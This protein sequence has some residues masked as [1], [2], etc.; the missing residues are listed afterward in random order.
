MSVF[1]LLRCK[2]CLTTPFAVVRCNP[3]L[4]ATACTHL[5]T[6]R[7]HPPVHPRSDHGREEDV[8]APGAGPE[9]SFCPDFVA[10]RL[11]ELREKLSGGSDGGTAES[12]PRK[13]EGQGLP[14]PLR[15]FGRVTSMLL[16]RGP[17]SSGR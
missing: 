8:G 7:P 9:S 15:V 4:H 2:P 1:A 12:S 5:R 3:P 14:N 6:H 17:S 10:E 13:D 16:R 11:K